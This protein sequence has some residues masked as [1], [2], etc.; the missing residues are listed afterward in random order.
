MIP[1]GLQ[2]LAFLIQI[3]TTSPS[4]LT[5]CTCDLLCIVFFL[6]CLPLLFVVCFEERMGLQGRRVY[7][8]AVTKRKAFLEWRS[9][10]FFC[11]D[12]VEEARR[13][14]RSRNREEKEKVWKGGIVKKGD[15]EVEEVLRVRDGWQEH[16][17]RS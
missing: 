13:K 7:Y 2:A 11:R 5:T 16:Q 9:G 4:A 10:R 6:S 1:L 15:D 8:L 12:N 3:L 14:Q 17:G